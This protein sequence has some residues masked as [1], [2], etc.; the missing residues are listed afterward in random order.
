MYRSVLLYSAELLAGVVLLLALLRVRLPHL[1]SWAIVGYGLLAYAVVTVFDVRDRAPDST[2]F[3]Y[4][5]SAGRA[6]WQGGDP[7][8]DPYV[9][10]P[11]TAGPLYFF[12]GTASLPTLAV[13]WASFNA[14][15]GLLLVPLAYRTLSAVRAPDEQKLSPAVVGL[16]TVLVGLSFSCRLGVQTGQF[17]CLVA[18]ALLA[19][20]F[21]HATGRR[22]WAGVCLAVATIKTGMML[23]FLLLFLRRRDWRVWAALILTCLALCLSTT[24]ALQY[25]IE[26][27]P[28]MFEKHFRLFRSGHGERLFLRQR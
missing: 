7:Y 4:F 1:A 12:F 8:S 19:A 27:L 18:L 13:I 11:P 3:V 6:L 5:W 10:N 9:L 26:S 17:S 22:V 16:L 23:P 28:G 24:P 14:H 2:D 20:L 15:G 25:Y 21:A